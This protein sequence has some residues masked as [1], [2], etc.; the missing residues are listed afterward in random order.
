MESDTL[1]AKFGVVMEKMQWEKV[2]G[3]TVD[4]LVSFDEISLTAVMF[5]EPKMMVNFELRVNELVIYALVG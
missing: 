5:A 4:Q 1:S 2:F 3:D